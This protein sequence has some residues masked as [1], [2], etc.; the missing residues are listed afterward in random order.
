[1]SASSSRSHL[2]DFALCICASV[3]TVIAT[4]GYSVV[5][6]QLPETDSVPRMLPYHGVLHQDG[7]PVTASGMWMR[8]DLETVDPDS[9]DRWVSYSQSMQVDVFDGK[10]TALLGP[11]GSTGRDRG[12][13][14]TN[15]SG[16]S[17]SSGQLSQTPFLS[18]AQAIGMGDDLFVRV[19]LLGEHDPDDFTCASANP[20]CP[21]AGD[22]ITLSNPQRLVTTPFAV[23]ASHTTD[24]HVGRSLIPD[25][26]EGTIQF[27]PGIFDVSRGRFKARF[28]DTGGPNGELLIGNIDGF[29]P[30]VRVSGPVNALTFETPGLRQFDAGEYPAGVTIGRRQFLKLGEIE[31]A[32]PSREESPGSWVPLACD[33]DDR[34]YSEGAIWYDKDASTYCLC[35]GDGW[36]VLSAQNSD[37]T[38][39]TPPANACSAN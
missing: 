39:I 16:F 25:N 32:V 3:C 15:Q 6:D 18:L 21:T 23:W 7:A 1:M 27:G 10:F 17:F 31:G 33:A 14:Y 29:E 34:L 13:H 4:M 30:R 2:R 12:Y 9:G 35:M 38:L 24:L 19:T 36:K 28:L 5:A 26:D 20:A 37:G 22:D 8:F 11:T